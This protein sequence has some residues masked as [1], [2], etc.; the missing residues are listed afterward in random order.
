MLLLCTCC[1]GAGHTILT[2]CYNVTNLV[3]FLVTVLVPYNVFQGRPGQLKL[4]V[5][6]NVTSGRSDNTL[7]A[8]LACF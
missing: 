4:R 8:L 2:P 5:H 7:A 6:G 3:T 1:D